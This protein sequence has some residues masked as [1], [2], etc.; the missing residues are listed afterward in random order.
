MKNPIICTIII[1]FN[2][3]LNAQNFIGLNT[4]QYA[5]LYSIDQN[6]AN[7]VQG[8]LVF[9]LNFLSSN[10]DV[11]ASNLSLDLGNLKTF[12]P[13]WGWLNFANNQVG[14]LNFS[15][16]TNVLSFAFNTKKK[17]AI[18]FTFNHRIFAE[19]DQFNTDLGRHI[20]DGFQ[21]TF[22]ES[23]IFSNPNAS[24]NIFSWADIGL[25][26]GRVIY[27]KHKHLLKGAFRV[28]WQLPMANL[29]MNVQNF[30]IQTIRQDTAI[31]RSAEF[32]YSYTD[33]F[34]SQINPTFFSSG[35]LGESLSN[36][37]VGFDIGLTYEFRPNS[38]YI[39]EGAK[40]PYKWKVGASILDIGRL[41]YDLTESESVR[42]ENSNEI[43]TTFFSDFDLFDTFWQNDDSLNVSVKTDTAALI[44]LPTKFNLNFDY[45]IY[46]GFFVNFNYRTGSKATNY[47]GEQPSNL[48]LTLRMESEGAGIYIPVQFQN[49]ETQIGFA[50]RLG[51]IMLGVTNLSGYFL[52]GGEP[53]RSSFFAG[54][55]LPVVRKE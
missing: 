37:T 26:Y 52:Y 38:R 36:G 5:G 55:R 20:R 6:P 12:P 34:S 23:P 24:V 4:S 41:K 13:S 39:E 28:K 40:Y 8:K 1:L 53:E 51:P 7:I 3:S 14:K 16:Q 42:K 2:L 15:S 45:Q 18:A 48:T 54:F 27:D 17:G 21:G 50:T 33:N 25:T 10:L 11:N 43:N 22:E 9:E 32:N 49:Q 46:K 30:D 47:Y 44:S 31:I 19:F 29:N 35:V